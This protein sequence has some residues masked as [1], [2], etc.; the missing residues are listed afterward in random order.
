LDERQVK[1]G[2]AEPGES[3]A[4]YGDALRRLSDQAT[5]LYTG[6]ARYWY[7]TQPGLTRLAQDR[8]A[9]LRAQPDLVAAELRRRL[10][11]EAKTRGD[12]ARVQAGPESSSAVPD[13]AEAR[14]VI[15]GPAHPHAA[16]QEAS[17]ARQTAAAWLE[18]RG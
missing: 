9:Q 4:S 5:F 12:F 2:C 16:R 14:L 6:G 3:V 7:A 18:T 1:L 11:R 10:G 8:A 17:P 13:T 15:L